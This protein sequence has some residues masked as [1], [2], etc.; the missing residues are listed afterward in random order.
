MKIEEGYKPSED[1]RSNP[2]EAEII[3]AFLGGMLW[4]LVLAVLV[5]ALSHAH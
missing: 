2:S 1:D 3:I 4:T 5:E